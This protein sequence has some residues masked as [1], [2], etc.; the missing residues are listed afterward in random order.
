MRFTPTRLAGAYIVDVEPHAD[1]R[2]AFARTFCVREFHAHGLDV[3]VR[4]CSVSSNRRRGTLRGLHFQRPPAAE[5][6][7][8]RC[9][10][11]AIHDVIVDLRPESPTY[12][13]HVGVELSAANRRALYVPKLFA[14]G[15]QTLA[16]E[17]EVFYQISEFYAP[18]TAAGLRFDDP[19]LDIHWPLQVA[20]LSD[21]DAAWPLIGTAGAAVANRS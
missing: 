11:G 4:Q 8:V 6:K 20:S 21:K 1:E 3:D 5:A 14:H 12:L 10:A 17:T 9:V 19:V 16:D 13:Q 15:F 2:G 7:L 18:E